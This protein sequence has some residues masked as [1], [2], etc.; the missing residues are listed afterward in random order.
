MAVDGIAAHVHHC[1]KSVGPD[2]LDAGNPAPPYGPIATLRSVSGT[3]P[4]IAVAVHDGFYGCGTGAGYAN[5]AFLDV[6]VATVASDVRLVVLPVWLSESN[7]ERDTHW[8]RAALARLETASVAV[9]PVRNGT[10]GM[11]RWGQLR[12]FRA[13][14]SDTSRVLATHVIP[15][16]DPLLV[17]AFDVPFLGLAEALPPSVR[18]DL[19]LVP[20]S[21]GHTHTPWDQERIAW[22]QTSLLGGLE[23]GTRIAAISGY[24]GRHLR[25]AYGV[26]PGALIE[27]HDGMVPEDRPAPRPHPLPPFLLC[28][29]RAEP[30][31]GYDDLLDALELLAA[32]GFTLP[33]LVLAATTEGTEPTAYQRSLQQRVRRL[34]SGATVI[35]RFDGAVR[36]LLAHPALRAVVVPSRAEPFGR[37]P[38]ETFLTGVAPVIATTAG[39]LAEQVVDGVTGFTAPPSAPVRLAS[40]IRRALNADEPTRRR[41][42]A[43]GRELVESRFDY[44]RNI[45]E[46]LM[47]AAPWAISATRAPS[48]AVISY[49]A[50]DEVAVKGVGSVSSTPWVKAPVGRQIPHWNTV[51]VERQVLVV[52]HNVTAA[53]RLLDV[54]PVFDSDPRVQ[55][56]CSWNGSDPFHHG[57]QELLDGLGMITIPWAQALQTRFDLAVT[58]NHG[59]LTEIDAPVVVLSHGIGYTK[60]S[61]GNRKPE[62]GNRKPETGNRKPETVRSSV[63]PRSGCS[64]TASPSPGRWSSRMRSSSP[65]WPRPSRRPRTPASSW[66][67]PATTGCWP[68]RTTARTTAALSAPARTTPS[69]P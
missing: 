32:E 51:R 7:P 30:Y 33:H 2:V 11:D 17:V 31:K 12:N 4:T 57:L 38:V 48:A 16:A 65:G 40:A 35:T 26:P 58:A 46:F 15:T 61:P 54:L 9:F 10:A 27:L 66:V 69:S 25:G 29:G 28:M 56:V 22:E 37:I 47:S 42:V 63:F 50:R 6:L 18:R 14:V 41:L 21:S 39:G 53:T 13:L 62:T 60:Q 19:V 64:T 55:V 20:R 3:R 8:H 43:T 49:G 67:T 5:R 36:G 1:S 23:H 59:G 52:V 45:R 44:H 24:M 34:G 68:A